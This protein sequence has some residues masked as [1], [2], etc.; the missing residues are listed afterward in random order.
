[1]YLK[2]EVIWLKAKDEWSGFILFSSAEARKV[3]Q[4]F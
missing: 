3:S 4:N 1:M 2:S